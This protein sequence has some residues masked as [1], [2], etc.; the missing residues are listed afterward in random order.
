VDLA[1]RHPLCLR[2][3]NL[4]VTALQ[5]LSFAPFFPPLRCPAPKVIMT[6]FGSFIYY[7]MGSGLLFGLFSQVRPPPRPSDTVGVF[8]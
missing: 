3:P 5:P 1:R 2:A 6:R 8:G 4:Q 7:L